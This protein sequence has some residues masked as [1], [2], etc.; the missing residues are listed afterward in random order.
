VAASVGAFAVGGG[1]LC[2]SLCS[3][4]YPASCDEMGESL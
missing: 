2:S 4:A 1:D 3:S